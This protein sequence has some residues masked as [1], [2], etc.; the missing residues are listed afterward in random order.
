MIKLKK[1]MFEATGM[2][3]YLLFGYPDNY[4]NNAQVLGVYGSDAEAKKIGQ[5]IDGSYVVPAV[6]GQSLEL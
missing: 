1:L 2:T 6:V 5:N 3:V 4:S